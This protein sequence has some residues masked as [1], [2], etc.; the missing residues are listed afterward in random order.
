MLR[1]SWKLQ[2]IWAANFSLSMISILATGGLTE[3]L[4]K[5]PFA[6]SLLAGCGWMVAGWIGA[7]QGA[8]TTNTKANPTLHA[9]AWGSAFSVLVVM[10]RIV[11]DLLLNSAFNGLIIWAICFATAGA[12][13]GFFS[14]LVPC[15]L[16]RQRPAR[17]IVLAA[18]YATK[19][20]V[21]FAIAMCLSIAA[22]TLFQ[23]F[24]TVWLSQGIY[25]WAGHVFGWGFAGAIGGFVGASVGLSQ[26]KQ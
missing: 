8:G 21:A 16:F 13:G 11:P 12:W 9:L 6:G 25:G 20:S 5:P 18:M 17:Y 23:Q 15:G 3:W 19:V 22:G 10:V 24:L 14:F 7:P 1:D 2:G 4:G 26:S